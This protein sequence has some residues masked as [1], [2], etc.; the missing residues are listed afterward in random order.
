MGRERWFYGQNLQR[1]GPVPLTQLVEAVLAQADPRATLVW[2]KGFAEWTRAEDVPE[3]ER[4]LAPYLARKE[5]EAAARRPPPPVAAPPSPVYVPAPAAKQASAVLYAGIGAAVVLVVGIGAWLMWPRPEPTIPPQLVPL[6][7]ETTESAPAVVI[8]A[9]GS[10]PVATPPPSVAPPPTAAPKPVVA[11]TP[12]PTAPPTSVPAGVGSREADLP[13]SEV[14]KLRGVAAWSGTT[15][16]L[17]V[18]NGTAWRVTALYVKIGRF[19]GDQFTEDNRPVLLLPPA[20]NVDAGVADLLSK[21]AP[22]RKKPGLNPLDTGPFEGEAGA[23]PESFRFEIESAR[24][25]PPA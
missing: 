14:K 15:L 9:P 21:V 20:R 13:P 19:T 25:Y 10:A 5:A 11:A 1:R 22:D 24:G 4:R 12:L 8:P 2:R 16:R 6:G 23:Q 7:G 17:T 18:Y 3:V